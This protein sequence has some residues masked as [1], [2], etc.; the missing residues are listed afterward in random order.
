M[1]LEEQDIEFEG[2]TIHT[3]EGGNGFPILML[4]GSGAGASI[5]S[6][7]ERVL[8]PMSQRH[9]VL[10]ADLIGFGQSGGKT[11]MPY[12]DIEMWLRQGEFLLDRLTAGPVGVIGHSLSGAFALKL[13]ANSDRI[14][15]VVATGTMGVSFEVPTGRHRAWSYPETA[16]DIRRVAES[17]VLDKSVVTDDQVAHREMILSKPGYREYFMAMFDRDRQHFIDSSALTEDELSRIDCEVLFVHGQQDV[18]FPPDKT[19]L[20]LAQAIPS[21]DVVL[22]SQCGHNVAYEQPEKF[23]HA[24]EMIFG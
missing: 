22:L 11:E 21:S 1:T 10:A 16:E 3:W 13:A 5:I 4:H 2:T 24:C 6:N 15:K 20:V 19:T 12:F 9:Q 18:S 17:M 23:L 14:S 7:F 8:E